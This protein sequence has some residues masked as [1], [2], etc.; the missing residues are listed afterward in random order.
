MLRSVGAEKEMNRNSGPRGVSL[1]G[2]GMDQGL[3]E[4]K[5][6]GPGIVGR[7]QHGAKPRNRTRVSGTRKE[8]PCVEEYGQSRDVEGGRGTCRGT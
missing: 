4:Q 3:T 5:H 2:G 7:Q 8:Q 1:G 6:R